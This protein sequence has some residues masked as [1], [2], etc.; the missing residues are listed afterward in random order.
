VADV[1]FV[2]LIVGFFALA[3]GLVKLCERIVGSVELSAADLDADPD[4]GPTPEE[5]GAAA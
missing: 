1:L 3:V 5:L 2:A 4:A